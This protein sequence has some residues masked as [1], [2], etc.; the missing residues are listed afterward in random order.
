LVQPH[1][2]HFR[3]SPLLLVQ[4]AQPVLVELAQLH[5]HEQAQREL[6]AQRV[7]ALQQDD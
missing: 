7:L 4:R 2:H 6:V 1:S 3:D 5:L